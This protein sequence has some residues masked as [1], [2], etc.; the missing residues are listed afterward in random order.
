VGRVATGDETVIPLT[1]LLPRQRTT[2]RLEASLAGRPVAAHI[3]GELPQRKVWHAGRAYRLTP[4][5]DDD[6]ELVIASARIR[7][8]RVIGLRLK[9]LRR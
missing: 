7:L 1:E 3:G 8:R 2:L 6:G 4:Q 5:L 9:R